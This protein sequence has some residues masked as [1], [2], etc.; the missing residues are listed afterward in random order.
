[1]LFSTAAERTRE[2]PKRG[3]LK[4]THKSNM[5]EIKG[6]SGMGDLKM[7]AFEDPR[8]SDLIL[9]KAGYEVGTPCLWK[10]SL[11]T[12]PPLTAFK[13]A[14][15]PNLSKMCPDN[16]FSGLQSR[17]LEIIENVCVHEPR[18]WTIFRR[19]LSVSDTL[20]AISRPPNG[21]LKNNCWDRFW[22]SLGVGAFLNAVRAVGAFAAKTWK[23][24]PPPT[25]RQ[26]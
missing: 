25:P 8:F 17:G 15:T 6:Q 20:L 9:L 22:T 10:H 26:F 13:N 7:P 5:D 16:C 19:V 18:K 4:I 12:L 14:P 3:T 24:P 21:A 1:M 11:R 2:L 23:I